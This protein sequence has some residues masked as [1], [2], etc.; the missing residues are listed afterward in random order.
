MNRWI[1]LFPGAPAGGGA[2]HGAR[3]RAGLG[4]V[5][6]APPRGRGGDQSAR[7]LLV[8]GPA[9]GTL[10]QPAGPGGGGGPRARPPRTPRPAL[11][12]QRPHAAG[13]QSARQC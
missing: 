5:T 2:G 8:T 11:A 10:G 4:A 9:A 12:R 13:G 1:V 3:V 7:G 6:P